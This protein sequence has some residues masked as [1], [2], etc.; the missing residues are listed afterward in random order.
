VPSLHIGTSGW[1]Y[2][3]W[4][5]IFYPAGLSRSKWLDYYAERYTSVEINSTFYR[6]PFSN[7]V[8][9]WRRRAPDGFVFSVKGSRRT[10]HTKKLQD[11]EEEVATFSERT[12]DLNEHLGPTLWQLPPQLRRNVDLL[13][14]FLRLL[15]SDRRHAVEFRH[16]SWLDKSVYR[17]LR[18]SQVALVSVSSRAMPPDFSLTA[19]FTYIRFH[20]LEGGFYHDYSKDEL[21]PWSEHVH[22]CLTRGLDVF[23]Y[24]NNDGDA[25]AT[26]NARLFR[27]IT[28][29]A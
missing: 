12:A 20:G 23:A 4:A 21:Q 29:K 10:T 19:E 11:V 15:P 28:A 7:M 8:S 3:D 26:A 6:L 22:N 1:S 25:H 17:L 27:E 18:A 2:K 9:S 24:F 14:D 16:P 5:G 13:G